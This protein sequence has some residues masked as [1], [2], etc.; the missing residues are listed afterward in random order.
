MATRAIGRIPITGMHHLKG[1][2]VIL[3]RLL[4]R[5]LQ[6]D[7]ALLTNIAWPLVLGKTMQKI[8]RSTSDYLV[9]SSSRPSDSTM[10]P[11]S[12]AADINTL[13]D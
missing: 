13:Q 6:Q 7:T 9:P 11:V 12:D 8:R 5:S 1:P 10:A 3:K 2:P 4:D